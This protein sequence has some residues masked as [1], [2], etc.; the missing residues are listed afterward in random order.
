MA[1]IKNITLENGISLSTA[2]IKIAEVLYFNHAH[3]VSFAEVVVNI[4]KD[5]Q[6]REDGRPEVIQ[7]KHRCSNSE[8]NTYFQLSVLSEVGKNVINQG[9][10]W[11]KTKTMYSGATDSLDDKE[12]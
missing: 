9:Y 12:S 4:Y 6:A 11:L 2:Y 7:F 5:Q 10:T 1:L 3:E 8:F